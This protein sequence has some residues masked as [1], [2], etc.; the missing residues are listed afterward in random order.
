[1]KLTSLLLIISLFQI[2]ANDVLSQ[3]KKISLD[4]EDVTIERVLNEIELKTG[5][6]FLY[7]N[8][9][10]DSDRIVSISEMIIAN[11]SQTQQNLLEA[12]KNFNELLITLNQ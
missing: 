3:N 1:M 9:V 8:N 12:Q 2:H 10:F 11:N 5:F 4:L 6:K 7:E